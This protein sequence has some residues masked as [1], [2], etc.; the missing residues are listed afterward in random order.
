MWILAL[1][2]SG[3]RT[4]K[5]VMLVKLGMNFTVKEGHLD[6]GKSIVL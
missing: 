1:R 6:K 3:R 4:K 5:N 2:I